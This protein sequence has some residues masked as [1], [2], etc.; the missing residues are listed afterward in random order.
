MIR[1]ENLSKK[2]G[3]LVVLND[4][5]AEIKKG[6]VISII[7]PSGTGKST[8]LR[9]LNLLET[10]TSGKI[11]IDGINIMDKGS[12]I[13]KIRQHMGMVFQ[14]FNLYEHLTVLE[15]LTLGPIKLLKI[16]KEQALETALDNLRIVGLLEKTEA[17]PDELSGGQK[18]RA[19]IARCLCMKPDIILFDEPTS[20]LDPTMV[21]EVLSVIKKLSKSGMTMAIVT[22]EMSFAKDVSNRV[23]YMDQGIIYEEGT[24]EQIFDNP[25]KDRT[26]AFVKRI[27]SFSYHINRKHFDFYAMNSEIEQFCDKHDLSKKRVH[28]LLLLIEESINLYFSVNLMPNLEITIQYSEKNNTI[29]IVLEYEGKENFMKNADEIVQ[30]I[31]QSLSKNIKHNK[32]GHGMSKITIEMK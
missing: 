20:A 16:S 28:N 3:D 23:F 30:S 21:S 32:A 1:V 2:F 27:R 5:N 7:G 13:Q 9:C 11:T 10:P 24:P 12:N 25:K 6:E 15:N 4:V 22:H 31:L 18:Q 17:F 8:F 14:S 19:A 29:S 26:I